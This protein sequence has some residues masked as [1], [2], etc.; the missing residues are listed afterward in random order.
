MD[1]QRTAGAARR[2]AAAKVAE[3]RAVD[4]HGNCGLNDCARAAWVQFCAPD[5]ACS[6][7]FALNDPSP[8][9]GLAFLRDM[10]AQGYT[11]S[12]RGDVVSVQSPAEWLPRPQMLRRA[13]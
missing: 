3:F 5:G 6:R 13:P 12:R 2:Y 8:R 1:K 11:I 4:G 10:L 7:P 9:E